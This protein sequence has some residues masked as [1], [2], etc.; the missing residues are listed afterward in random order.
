MSKTAK[1]NKA[2]KP[3]AEF[4]TEASPKIAN[5]LEDDHGQCELERCKEKT[6]GRWAGRKPGLVSGL[7]DPESCLHQREQ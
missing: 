7:A 5:P 1:Q 6:H 3:R 4:R 2:R